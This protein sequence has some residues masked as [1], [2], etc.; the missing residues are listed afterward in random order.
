MITRTPTRA[1][2]LVLS[3]S[4]LAL[5]Q[6]ASAEEIVSQNVGGA[7]NL[8]TL[9]LNVRKVDENA[10]RVPASVTTITKGELEEQRIREVRDVAAVTPGLQ[11]P[12]TGSRGLSTANI[13]GVG[14]FFPLAIDDTSVPFFVDGIPVIPRTQDRDYFDLEQIDVLRGP[15]STLYGRNA[16]AGAIVITTASPSEEPEY[17]INLEVT[18]DDGYRV[19]AIASGPLTDRLAYRFSGQYETFDGDIPLLGVGGRLG[20]TELWQLNGKLVWDATENTTVT[21]SLRYDEY[22]ELGSR[23]AFTPDGVF[24]TLLPPG[25]FPRAQSDIKPT[26]QIETLGAGLT[27]EHEFERF[28]FTSVTGY[29]DYDGFFTRDDTDRLV[30]ALLFGVPFAGT[31]FLD[32]PNADRRIINEDG[33]QFTQEFR[34]DGDIGE[35]GSWVAGI[36]YYTIDSDVSLDFNSTMFLDGVFDTRSQTDSYSVFGEATVPVND[37]ARI[38]GGLRY[39]YEDKNYDVVYT[40]RSGGLL[41]AS[42]QESRS[43][44]FDFLTGRLGV[45]YDITDTATG[46][47][48]I[49]RG[50]KSGGF[51]LGD[52]DVRL[53]GNTTSAFNS[54]ETTT[55]EM[56]IR[57]TTANG[58][59]DFAVSVFYNETQDDNIQ[60]FALV[61]LSGITSQIRDIDTKSYGLEFQARHD[62]TSRWVVE[63]T[64]SLL[65]AE[66]TNFTPATV[67]SPAIP[68]GN[69]L[70]Y[71]PQTSFSI[72]TQYTAPTPLF[73]GQGDFSA[74]LEYI[75]VGDRA[76]NIENS[77]SVSSYG[78]FNA[79][80]GWE[81]D[82]LEVY[83]FADNLL[84]EDFAESAFILGTTMTATPTQLIGVVPGRPRKVGVGVTLNF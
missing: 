48:T 6:G 42:A 28:R 33:Q 43:E 24:P 50:V 61:G 17:S 29:Q 74:R 16:Q 83:A 55:Y 32:D 4:V 2:A 60:Q 37:R 63:G 58:L 12:D 81:S 70:P 26:R 73:G 36:S 65:K 5:T 18:D 76:A 84:D 53:P 51:E 22:D 1:V 47:A 7:V 41:G 19:R 46:F 30:A 71:A 64:L 77:L 80:I 15:Q 34:L 78:V 40:D 3:T 67:A 25:G 9:V 72:A 21:A 38:I 39:T 62:I 57:G 52:L 45:S 68:I 54:A 49:S 20:D 35:D 69:D 14:S 56:G 59:T 82:S 11:L 66:T 10:Q 31:A 27:I 23:G 44:T 13:R 8:G 75:Y 79:R